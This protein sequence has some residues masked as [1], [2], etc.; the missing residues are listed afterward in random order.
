MVAQPVVGAGISHIPCVQW[1]FGAGSSSGSQH[2]AGAGTYLRDRLG[3][4]CRPGCGSVSSSS[5]SSSSSRQ[6]PSTSAGL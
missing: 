1:L 3:V 5:S 2:R 4:D 6:S